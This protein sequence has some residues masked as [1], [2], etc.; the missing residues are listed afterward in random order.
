MISSAANAL[1]L[2]AFDADPLDEALRASSTLAALDEV[3]RAKE[4]KEARATL[5]AHEKAEK[6]KERQRIKDA[7]SQ[8]QL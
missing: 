3:K 1:D 5:L 4:I 8:A 2:A 7:E 6:A